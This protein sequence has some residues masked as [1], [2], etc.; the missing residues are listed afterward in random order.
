MERLRGTLILI[1]LC[2]Y[3]WY[4]YVVVHHLNMD[5]NYLIGSLVYALTAE[6]FITKYSRDDAMRIPPYLKM[7]GIFA[8]YVFASKVFLTDKIVEIGL[9]KYLYRDPFLRA[10]CAVLII[11]N[12]AFDKKLIRYSLHFLFATLLLAGAVS[13]IQ[14][15]DPLFFQ[16]GVMAG[17]FVSLEQYQQYLESLGPENVREITPILEGYRYSIYSWISGISIGLDSMSIFSILLGIKYHSRLKKW[18]LFICGGLIS[19]LSSSRWIMLN[20]VAVISQDLVGRRNLI[21]RG[22]KLLIITVVALFIVIQGASMI[23]LDFERMWQERLLSDSANSRFFAFEVFDKVFY[24]HPIF[25]TGGE[26]TE[27]MTMLLQGKSSQI[28]VGWLKLL[29]YYGLVGAVIYVSFVYLLM[30]HLYKLAL[31]RNYWG[32]FFAFFAFVLANCTL[33]ELSIFY[34]GLLLALLY[35]RYIENPMPAIEEKNNIP[36]RRLKTAGEAPGKELAR[37]RTL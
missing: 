20:F 35:A 27:R 29:Y 3:P 9:S 32:S 8:I 15:S 26:D 12:T 37:P 18:L 16:N 2:I 36:G 7:L 13:L 10:W 33:V 6:L 23:G 30:R 25:G 24:E 34:H 1:A 22:L 28:H 11:E 19:F 31:E 5:P 4:S 21:L 17:N 14:V